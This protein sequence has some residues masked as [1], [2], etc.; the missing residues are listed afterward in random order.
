MLLPGSGD[1]FELSSTRANGALARLLAHAPFRT[2]P[3]RVQQFA[4]WVMTDNPARDAFS[5]IAGTASGKPSDD[6]L[7]EVRKLLEGVGVDLLAYRTFQ[8]TDRLSE[9]LRTAATPRP[10]LDR[11]APLTKKQLQEI[12]N[13]AANLATDDPLDRCRAIRRAREAEFSRREAAAKDPSSD[14][15]PR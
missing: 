3:F 11:D 14:Q 12:Q 9:F 6:E 2:A 10:E 15:G 5:A 4:I 1:S 13:W 7:R 8:K